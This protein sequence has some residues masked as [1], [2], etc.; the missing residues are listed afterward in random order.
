MGRETQKASNSPAL[1]L[2]LLA[3]WV[4][5]CSLAFWYL[6]NLDPGASRTSVASELAWP[7]V[8]VL[9]GLPLLSIALLGGLEVLR[10]VISLKSF[11][12]DL[13]QQVAALDNIGKQFGS[14]QRSIA[15][16]ASAIDQSTSQLADLQARAK[17]QAKEIS[18]DGPAREADLATRLSDHLGRAKDYFDRAA[19]QYEQD[20]K[21]GV[22][23]VQGWILPEAVEMLRSSGSLSPS[24]AAYL[25]ASLDV[26]RRTRRSGRANLTEAELNRLDELLSQIDPD[27]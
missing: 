5:L 17:L 7:F 26:D 25:N 15:D 22:K 20:N 16:A 12:D 1:S 6:I 18:T 10:Q 3:V 11:M 13:P 23:R 24:A 8:V 4:V 9:L 19:S 27:G 2:I 21:Q 14:A